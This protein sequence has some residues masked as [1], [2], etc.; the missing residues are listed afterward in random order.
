MFCGALEGAPESWKYTPVLFKG[1]FVDQW[2][3]KPL[4]IHE[5]IRLG[6]NYINP[7][8][9][10]ASPITLT[11]LGLHLGKFTKTG[12]FDFDQEKLTKEEIEKKFKEW[13]KR[14]IKE[15]PKS[16]SWTSGKPNRYQ[17]AFEIPENY[18]DL[19]GNHN[20]PPEL[21]EM[22]L[23]WDKLQSVLPP[24]KHPETGSYKWINSPKE[25]PLAKAPEWFLEGWARLSEKD[26]K[27]KKRDSNDI[28]YRRTRDEL[29]YDSSR[30]E[31]GLT[32]Y[33]QD[34]KYITFSEYEHWNRI[35]MALHSLSKEWEEASEGKIVDLHLDEWLTWS[36]KQHNYDYS[37]C[38]KKWEK[39]YKEEGG[40]KINTFFDYC[41][42]NP[43]HKNHKE[44]L[45]RR[46]MW[47]ELEELEG[48]KEPPKRK[49]TELLNDIFEAALRGDKD[50]YAE[51][52]AEMEVRFRKRSQD[53]HIELLGCLRNK[54]NKKTY[55][56]GIVDMSKIKCLDYLLEGYALVG[57]IGMLYAPFG[58][59]KTSLACGMIRAGFNKVGF[60]DQV[61]KRDGF[62]S[63]FI[64]SDGGAS[65]FAEVYQPLGL[66]PEM[67]KVMTA[68]TEQGLK[69][70]KCDLG[71]LIYLHDFLKE[72][73]NIKFI[74]ID[75]VK[76]ML[77]GT[78][79]KYTDNE[80]ADL[81]IGFLREIIAEPLGVSIML[82][83]HNSSQGD[84]SSGAKRWNE[85]C[86]WVAQIKEVKDGEKINDKQRKLCI[87][88]D[89]KEG[90]RVFDYK[91][92]ENGLFVPVYNSDMKGDCFGEL[93]QHLQQINF[94]TGRKVFTSKDFH[95]INYSSAQINRT[96]AEHC[97][98][99]DGIL[100]KQK[101]KDGEVVRGKYVL[102][103]QHILLNDDKNQQKPAID[104]DFWKI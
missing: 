8:K 64:M 38:I 70:W 49:K 1:G 19:L 25:V 101:N 61:R 6:T 4:S 14:E 51:D 94:A 83:S 39:D 15:L 57:E 5:A 42:S 50:S 37:K 104:W 87:W 75:S 79:F 21:P 2:N 48:K 68:D 17:V 89:P 60:L 20:S 77:S 33:C 30:V 40:I 7:T 28:K 41:E 100:K 59:G 35:G 32:K 95:Q 65:R 76:S 43:E 78:P 72:R 31:E 99:R 66:T 63:L 53:I 90:R 84:S 26:I 58:A 85:A 16:I 97:K 54:Y 9:D 18:W 45:R 98:A 27:P 44:W 10:D 52:F 86:G 62:E 81:I 3:K 24:S 46:K 93:K 12:C 71:G 82:L 103:T 23:R 47:E 55:K 74:I 11:G 80:Q 91:V 56:V 34:H 67:V 96:V 36:S 88:K 102:K 92:D 29:D 73:P 13:F 69:N 22:E